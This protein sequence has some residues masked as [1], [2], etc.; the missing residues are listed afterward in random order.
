M[1]KKITN[2]SVIEKCKAVNGDR[3]DYSKLEYINSKTPLTIICKEHGEFR[4]LLCN[5]LKGCGCPKCGGNNRMKTEEYVS[6]IKS[7]CNC[8]NIL[9]DKV[10]YINNHTPITLVCKIHG[11]WNTLPTSLNKNIECPEC[12]KIRLHNKYAKTT[13]EFIKEAYDV[14]QNK[15][16]YSRVGYK[17]NKTK[18]CIIC[19]IHGEFWQ[20]PNDHLR[21]Q[22]CPKCGQDL[23]WNKRGRMTTEKIVKRFIEVHGDKYNYDNVNYISSNDK[24]EIVCKKHGTFLQL[25]YAHIQGCGCPKCGLETLSKRFAKTTDEFITEA[26]E[27]HGNLYDYSKV[28]YK[29]SATKVEI[30]CKKHGSFWQNPMSHL[31]GIKCPMCYAELSVSKNE[32]EFQHFVK[33]LCIGD[34]VKFNVRNIISP[35]ELD[36]VNETKKIAIEYDGL[37]WHSNAKLKDPLYHLNKTNLCTDK[38]YRLIHIF[39]DEWVDKKEFVKSLIEEVMN[40]MPNV[41]SADDCTC[42]KISLDKYTNFVN[43]NSIENNDSIDITYGL[44]YSNELVSVIGIQN[45]GNKVYKI[46]LYCSKLHYSVNGDLQKMLNWFINEYSPTKIIAEVNKRFYDG[47]EYADCG[48]SHVVD[49]QPLAFYTLHGKD[50]LKVINNS[51]LDEYHKI[52]DCGMEIFELNI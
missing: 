2:E 22:G 44:Y 6:R 15:Y 35:L 14:H 9:F 51:K 12:Q 43:D 20:N 8:P 34:D 50:R 46:I 16:D 41:I 31:K 52:Y 1:G 13:K 36:I 19:S 37:Y 48:F 11:E 10:E 49:T 25:P 30:I 40:K 21:G 23:M 32:I 26:K 45:I 4:Q 24:V 42:T 7:K 3:Y 38:G 28:D 17:D 5:H 33:N 29:N 39:E 27:V 18:V 47:S